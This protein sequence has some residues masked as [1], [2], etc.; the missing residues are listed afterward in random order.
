MVRKQQNIAWFQSGPNHIVL[1]CYI[2]MLI[3]QSLKLVVSEDYYKKKRDE[4]HFAC[5]LKL[6]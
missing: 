4:N 3:S 2:S 5:I 6:I 1:W